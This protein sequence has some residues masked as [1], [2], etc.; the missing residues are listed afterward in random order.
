MDACTAKGIVSRSNIWEVIDKPNRTASGFHWCTSLDVFD[1]ID[2]TKLNKLKSKPES[3]I[4]KFLED[5]GLEVIQG[6]RKLISPYEIDLYIP[7]KNFAIEYNGGFWHDEEEM[8]KYY[9]RKPT[10][11]DL[12]SS[13]CK[14]QGITLLHIEE[15]DFLANKLLVLNTLKDYLKIM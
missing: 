12:K 15:S 11:K 14:E 9:G 3:E 8:L 7:S 6:S 13:L 2:F 5:L 4:K 10:P 1:G